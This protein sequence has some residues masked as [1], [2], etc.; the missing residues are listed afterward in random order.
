MRIKNSDLL[1][2]KTAELQFKN[3]NATNSETLRELKVKFY[4]FRENTFSDSNIN[5]YIRMYDIIVYILS[6]SI[7]IQTKIDIVFVIFG[8]GSIPPISFQNYV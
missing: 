2:V 6:K 7:F 4:V 1:I 5:T 3:H 8:P